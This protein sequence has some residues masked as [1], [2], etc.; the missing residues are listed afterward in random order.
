MR[1]IIFI[2]AFFASVV[3]LYYPTLWQEAGLLLMVFW[4]GFLARDVY[5]KGKKTK[6]EGENDYE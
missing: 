4:A 2:Q 5:G 3:A 1:L 6:D